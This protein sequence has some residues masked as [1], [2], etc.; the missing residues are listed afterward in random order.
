[1]TT[2]PFD[3]HNLTFDNKNQL[4]LKKIVFKVVKVI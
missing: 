1:M 2:G 3:G 4:I